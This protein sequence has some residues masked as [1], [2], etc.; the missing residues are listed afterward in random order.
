[1]EKRN[2]S[3]E[4]FILVMNLYTKIPYGQFHA[5]NPEVKKL[6]TLLDRTPGAIAYKLVHFSGLDPYHKN[7]GI[8]GLANPGNNAI[9][10]YNEFVKNWDEMLYDSELLLAK[11]QNKS[12]EETTLDKDEYH[13]LQN[14]LLL[15][16]KG[17]NVERLVKARVNQSLFRKVIIGNYYKACAICKL[18]ISNLLVASHILKWSENEKHRLNPQN[19][20]CLCN[21]HDRAFELGYIGITPEYT[22]SISNELAGI[23]E[24]ETFISIFQRHENRKINLPDKYYPSTDFLSQHFANTFKG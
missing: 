6:A 16:K 14:D 8:K 1:M 19:G 20:I 21:T 12:I 15:G 3:R 7:R 11:Y 9:A 22:I 13:S 10:I 24:K 18:D 4:E 17:I 2:W 23:K 5:N